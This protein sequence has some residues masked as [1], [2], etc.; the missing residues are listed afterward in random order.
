M[1][2]T[3][4]V[5]LGA[6]VIGIV[7]VTQQV[8]SSG[9]INSPPDLY[10]QESLPSQTQDDNSG[11]NE[12][13]QIE[14]LE[15]SAPALLDDNQLIFPDGD[16]VEINWRQHIRPTV[17]N[18][19]ADNYE[20]LR[21]AA[22][23]GDAIVSMILHEKQRSCQSRFESEED[24]E[25][26]VDQL[27]QTH[28]IPFPGQEQPSGISNPE[29]I[30]NM[31]FILRDHF[32]DCQKF[33]AYQG[34]LNEKWLERSAADGWPV[35]MVELG[36]QQEAPESA[37]SY[38]QEAWEAGSVEGLELLA[39]IIKQSYESGEDPSANVE[40][41]AVLHTYTIIESALLKDHGQVAGRFT[42]GLKANLEREQS[43][44][45]PRELRKAIEMSKQMIR[46]NPN[47]C[48]GSE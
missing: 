41:F 30:E 24:L 40:A 13:S 11:V 38:Y 25:A 46:S 9:P 48:F 42:A 16:V 17:G 18:F 21:E 47:C 4:L 45:R 35:A 7:V 20:V 43:L 2:A 23:N 8:D 14:A 34:N 44:L 33:V 36:Q 15:S 32:T 29:Y 37:K 39:E 5:L 1:K 22:L 6:I 12:G 28:T 26:A 10:S 3:L 27:H 19:G 31:E